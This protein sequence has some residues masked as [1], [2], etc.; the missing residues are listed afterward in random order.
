MKAD[1]K[2]DKMAHG[3]DFLGYPDCGNGVYSDKLDYKTWY[4]FNVKQRAY[5]NT[6]EILTPAVMFLMI[7]GLEAPWVAIGGG[8]AFFFGRLFYTIGYIYKAK[9]RAPGT[10]LSNLAILLMLGTAIYSII[11]MLHDMNQHL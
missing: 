1:G 3:P 5:K 6:L 9:Y 8:I 10:M 2:S 7:G 4:I 11:K